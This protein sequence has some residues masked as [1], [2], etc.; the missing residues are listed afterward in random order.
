M[1]VFLFCETERRK[2]KIKNLSEKKETP[3]FFRIQYRKRNFS[4]FKGK[5]SLPEAYCFLEAR[6]WCFEINNNLK[7][8]I[9]KKKLKKKRNVLISLF[10]VH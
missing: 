1:T 4:F 5:E 2:N 3:I 10:L 9:G 6:V 7:E 8:K